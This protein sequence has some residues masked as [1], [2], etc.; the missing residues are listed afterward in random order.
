MRKTLSHFPAHL[1]DTGVP[2]LGAASSSPLPLGLPFWKCVLSISTLEVS[3][4]IPVYLKEIVE[5][6]TGEGKKGFFYCFIGVTDFCAECA[7]LLYVQLGAFTSIFF[8]RTAVSASIAH[9]LSTK[10]PGERALLSRQLLARVKLKD[11]VIVF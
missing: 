6:F 9:L 7:S 1:H 4:S 2:F 8:A 3:I 11:D 5:C 10:E